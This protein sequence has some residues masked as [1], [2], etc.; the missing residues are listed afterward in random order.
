MVRVMLEGAIAK[1]MEATLQ[2]PPTP[3][4]KPSKGP[5]RGDRT[6]KDK[7]PEQKASCER[8]VKRKRDEEQREEKQQ[9]QDNLVEMAKPQAQK[10]K[11]KNEQHV[12]K[13]RTPMLCHLAVWWC[14]FGK[15]MQ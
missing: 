10:F 2:P 12:A 13:L 4:K 3:A 5:A 6:V 1:A 8:Y 7:M 15:E 9:F 11:K 14:L